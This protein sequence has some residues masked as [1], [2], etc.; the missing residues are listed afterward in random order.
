MLPHDGAQHD[1][2]VAA[3]SLRRSTSPACSAGVVTKFLT[4]LSIR[5]AWSARA[6]ALRPWRRPDSAESGVEPESDSGS[7]RLPTGPLRERIHRHERRLMLTSWGRAAR[8]RFG[9][10]TRFLGLVAD[11]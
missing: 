5:F 9:R 2:F 11:I 6:V 1:L 4:M 3:S 8:A 7:S 10:P